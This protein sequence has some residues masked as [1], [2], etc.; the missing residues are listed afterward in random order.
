[1]QNLQFFQKLTRERWEKNLAKIKTLED[2]RDF[3]QQ[4]DEELTARVVS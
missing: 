4:H 2:S 3:L 1:M